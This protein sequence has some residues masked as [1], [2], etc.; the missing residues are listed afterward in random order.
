MNFPQQGSII[1][2]PL[3]LL[4]EMPNLLDTVWGWGLYKVR[5]IRFLSSFLCVLALFLQGIKHFN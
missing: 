4:S 1:Q 2:I 3:G 5:I